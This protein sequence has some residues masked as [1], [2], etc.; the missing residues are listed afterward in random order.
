MLPDRIFTTGA[1]GW[2]TWDFAQAKEICIYDEPAACV[3]RLQ[4]L[5][6]QLSSMYQCILEFNRRGKDSERQS[7]GIDAA[8]R[9]ERSCRSCA[10]SRR[11][12][13]AA[14]NC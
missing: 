11:P 7:T 8:L 6:E 13:R 14:Q 4:C 12:V 1:V 10:M 3:E 2:M 9:R 5:Q